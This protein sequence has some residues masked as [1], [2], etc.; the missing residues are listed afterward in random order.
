MT[1]DTIAPTVGLVQRYASR[2]IRTYPVS[3]ELFSGGAECRPW[4]FNNASPATRR[5]FLPFITWQAI[6]LFTKTVQKP[7]GS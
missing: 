1:I 5:L 6:L 3:Q 4:R 7:N 2:C